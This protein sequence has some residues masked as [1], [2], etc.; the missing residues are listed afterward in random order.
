MKCLNWNQQPSQMKCRG[1]NGGGGTGNNQPNSAPTQHGPN[2]NPFAAGTGGSSPN[3]HGV[4]NT[5]SGGAGMAGAGGYNISPTGTGG[6]GGS[7]LIIVAYPTTQA[8]GEVRF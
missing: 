7:G 6:N 8:A 2:I 5:G 4:A 1:G 3:Q